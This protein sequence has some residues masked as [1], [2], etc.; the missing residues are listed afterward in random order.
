MYSANTLKSD[1]RLRVSYH[2]VIYSAIDKVLYTQKKSSVI[3]SANKLLD[4]SVIYSAYLQLFNC[5][6]LIPKDTGKLNTVCCDLTFA[7]LG[8]LIGQAKKALAKGDEILLKRILASLEKAEGFK[9]IEKDE[10]NPLKNY[11]KGETSRSGLRGF[12]E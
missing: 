1:I 9:N 10:I 3:Y 5:S 6:N 11:E 4:T 7:S 12:T 8:F 2:C